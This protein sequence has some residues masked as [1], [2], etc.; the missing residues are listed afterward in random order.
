MR[1]QA[2]VDIGQTSCFTQEKLF[3]PPDELFAIGIL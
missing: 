3:T 1:R 2:I